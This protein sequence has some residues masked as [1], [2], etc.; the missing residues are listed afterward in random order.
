MNKKGCLLF[1]WGDTLM[2]VFTEYNRSMVSWSKS[3][4]NLFS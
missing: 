1:D 3:V 4:L 2:K